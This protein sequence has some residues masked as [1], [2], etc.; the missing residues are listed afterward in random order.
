MGMQGRPRGWWCM[1][2]WAR[3][4]WAAQAMTAPVQGVL[5]APLVPAAIEVGAA[6]CGALL[7]TP[8][9]LAIPFLLA[10]GMQVLLLSA[11]AQR[12]SCFRCRNSTSMGLL[13]GRCT[14]SCRPLLLGKLPSA[15]PIIP[16]K[17]HP[18]AC[19]HAQGFSRSRC[20]WGAVH[21]SRSRSAVRSRVLCATSF[22]STQDLL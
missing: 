2:M 1:C 19:S 9:S 17:H 6:L 20:Q 10:A 12:T 21:A 11:A 16:F 4:R 3:S 18:G 8:L 14:C 13:C 15:G 7:F 22:I 5:M